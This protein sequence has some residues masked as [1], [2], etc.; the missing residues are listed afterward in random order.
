MIDPKLLA[1]DFEDLIV[2]AVEQLNA[3]EIY[4]ALNQAINNQIA[5]HKKEMNTLKELQ[6]LMTGS[7][8]RDLFLDS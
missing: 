5:W 8:Q 7:P 3:T 6:Y 2:G 4:A 1:A